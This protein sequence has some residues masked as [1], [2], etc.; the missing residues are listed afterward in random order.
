MPCRG[1]GHVISNLGGKS[2]E[3]TCPWCHGDGVRVPE[4]DAQATWVEKAA[5][6]QGVKGPAARG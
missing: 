2:Q 4:V 5:K 6:A 1:T 3:I